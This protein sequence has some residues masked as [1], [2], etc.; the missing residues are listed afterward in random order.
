MNDI[1]LEE[2]RRLC[3]ADAVLWSTHVLERLQERGILR[4]DVRN[5]IM[6]GEIIEHYPLDYPYLYLSCLILGANIAGQSIR[7]MRG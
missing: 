3:A 4:K 7:C 2:L 5:A 6:T 1:S